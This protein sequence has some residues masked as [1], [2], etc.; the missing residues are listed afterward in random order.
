MTLW[1]I[2]GAIHLLMDLTIWTI[3][4]PSIFSIMHNLSTGKKIL[5]A[6]VF[7]VGMMSWC[8]VILRI[9]FR[10]YL[11]GL[12]SD[13]TYNGPIFMVLYVIEISLAISCVSVATFRP[14]VIM[15][16]KRFKKLWG[17][18]TSTTEIETTV[19]RMGASPLR[20]QP[21]ALGDRTGTSG[22]KGGFAEHTTVDPEL[23][24]Y[25]ALDTKRSQFVQETGGC[26][27]RAGD[28]ELGD[29]IADASSSSSLTSPDPAQVTQ[30]QLPAPAAISDHSSPHC[31]TSFYAV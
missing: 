26:S 10:K 27:C 3:P 17:I 9:S 24:E 2:Y 14:L 28:A 11:A 19:Y 16:T 4:L 31:P 18:P 30:L 29:T 21:K 22:N 15:I 8:S 1:F 20:V 23:V 7:T 13:P 5:L 25:V 12:G 6:M